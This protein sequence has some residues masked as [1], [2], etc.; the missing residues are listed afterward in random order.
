MYISFCLY[1][2]LIP[3][4]TFNFLWFFYNF[5]NSCVLCRLVSCVIL[6]V[7]EKFRIFFHSQFAHG[8]DGQPDV[9]FLQEGGVRLLS[10][11][12][13]KEWVEVVTEK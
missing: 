6:G 12:K 10:W 8:E 5:E 9:Y 3:V 1:Y 2:S 11:E 4:I 13:K 7:W